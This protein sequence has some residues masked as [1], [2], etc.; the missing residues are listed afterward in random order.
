MRW[1]HAA[2]RSTD[3]DTYPVLRFS[4]VPPVTVR[5]IDR[6]DVPS[7]GAG[8]AAQGPTPA[9]IAN[10]VYRRGRHTP[11]AHPVHPG[12]GNGGIVRDRKSGHRGAARWP[13][14]QV[15]DWPAAALPAVGMS[16]N[17]A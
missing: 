14:R 2:I 16:S 7:V 5:L 8:E 1:D 12:A 10:A 15:V 11:A 3:W 4:E 17:E 9:A 13:R 6:P